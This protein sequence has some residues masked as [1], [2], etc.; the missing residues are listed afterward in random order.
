MSSH[1][2]LDNVHTRKIADFVSSLQY[3]DIPEEV[4]E[5]CKLLMLDS[6]GCGLYGADL[7][8][9]RILQESLSA[10]DQNDGAAVWGR[11]CG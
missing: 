3:D 5:C 1:S 7:P 11:A 8:W 4:R 10:L 2:T 6:L 9:T